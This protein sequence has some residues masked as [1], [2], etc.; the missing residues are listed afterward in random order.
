MVLIKLGLAVYMYMDWNKYKNATYLTCD[1]LYAYIISSR[2][3][4]DHE[5][6]RLNLVTVYSLHNYR[7]NTLKQIL[8]TYPHVIRGISGE[9]IIMP[10]EMYLAK[11][12]FEIT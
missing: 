8:L 12:E 1:E 2:V 10:F 4:L 7:P 5:G 3:K 9:Q 6:I 11:H